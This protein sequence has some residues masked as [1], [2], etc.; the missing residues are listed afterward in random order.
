MKKTLRTKEELEKEF[1]MPIVFRIYKGNYI[2]RFESRFNFLKE[3]MDM[4][5][6]EVEVEP[7]KEID[8]FKSR[9]N[10][11]YELIWYKYQFSS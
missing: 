8:V 10:E 3:Q 2:H 5:G 6:K 11:G 9:S 1:A 4:A 7:T